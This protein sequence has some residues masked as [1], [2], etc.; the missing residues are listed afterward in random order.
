M[1]YHCHPLSTCHREIARATHRAVG[2]RHK[3]HGPQPTAGHSCGRG[4][5]AHS[6]RGGRACRCRRVGIS[7]LLHH[8]GYLCRTL[9]HATAHAAGVHLCGG[10]ATQ[11]RW[12][13]STAAARPRDIHRHSAPTTHSTGIHT[14]WMVAAHATAV[15]SVGAAC[16]RN[17]VH[18]APTAR[19]TQIDN[20]VQAWVQPRDTLE[21]RH[22]TAGA[23]VPD[24]THT[25]H[26]P[27]GHQMTMRDS[28]VMLSQT[29]LTH[30]HRTFEDHRRNIAFF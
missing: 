24:H 20:A 3:C 15:S 2:Q 28:A 4:H 6:R 14:P 13:Q 26:I 8:D 11:S 30:G 21:Q 29:Y 9:A 25:S 23:P 27:A 7:H 12:R 1:R 18:E 5:H 19:T 22:V 16:S 10:L 17:G